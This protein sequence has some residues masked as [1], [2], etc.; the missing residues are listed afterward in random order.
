[1]SEPERSFI[2]I[3]LG[4]SRTIDGTDVAVLVRA[5]WPEADIRAVLDDSGV[6][7]SYRVTVEFPDGDSAADAAFRL[8]DHL[9]EIGCPVEFS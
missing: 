5:A 4:H 8:R 6:L 1:M 9:A 7:T 3:T 2:V